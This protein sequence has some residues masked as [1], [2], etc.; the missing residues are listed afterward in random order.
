MWRGACAWSAVAGG[1]TASDV[2]RRETPAMATK[3]TADCINCGACEAEC[4]NAAIYP[5]GVSWRSLD[6]SEHP[7]L[8]DDHFYIAPERCTECVGFH[9]R[10]ACAAVCPVDCCVPDPGSSET[11]EILIARAKQLHPDM[12]FGD[13]WPSRFRAGRGESPAPPHDAAGQAAV[14]PDNSV[15]PSVTAA[16]GTERGRAAGRAAG[17]GEPVRATASGSEGGEGQGGEKPAL[18]SPPRPGGDGRGGSAGGRAGGELE[19]SFEEV[20]AELDAGF[21]ERAQWWLRVAFLLSYV[22]P[23]LGALPAWAKQTLGARM[24]DERYFDARKATVANVV[25]NVLLYP[26][27]GAAGALAA[28]SEGAVWRWALGGLVVAVVEG[29]LRA[30]ALIRPDSKGAG[31]FRGAL[32]G[33]ALVPLASALAARVGLRFEESTVGFD[34]FH[35]GA[36]FEEKLERQRRYGRVYRVLERPGGYVIA[37]EFP[38]WL[39]PTSLAQELGLGPRMPEYSYDVSLVDSELVVRGRV[40]DPRVRKLTAIAPSFPSEFAARVRLG[41]RVRGFKHRY[42]DRLLEVIVPKVEAGQ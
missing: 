13:E 32:Y 5:G 11:E 7:P 33:H 34:G 31:N 40:T 26:V 12:A 21:G 4:P 14:V 10:E 27:L 17:G 19:A 30:P 25:G 24:G 22:L 36:G 39:P 28:G 6:G 3:I 37:V 38:R 16:S 20:A 9:D 8:S 29:L 23:L 35:A 18:Q 42:R 2:E 1:P 41:S 15:S